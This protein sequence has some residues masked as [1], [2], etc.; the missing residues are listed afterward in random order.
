MKGKIETI[1]TVP[2]IDCKIEDYNF[3]GLLTRV[4]RFIFG[5]ELN[6]LN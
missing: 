1:E 6:L 2:Q 3:Q 4:Y 5:R